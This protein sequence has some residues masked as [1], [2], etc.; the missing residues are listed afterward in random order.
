MFNELGKCGLG[1][2]TLEL[3][4]ANDVPV[5]HT[6]MFCQSEGLALVGLVL[7]ELTV[8]PI[9]TDGDDV[10]V[11]PE[12]LEAACGVRITVTRRLEDRQHGQAQDN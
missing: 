10:P 12:V 8:A 7:G 5:P 4:D 6:R 2:V 11:K 3:V 1:E 9:W